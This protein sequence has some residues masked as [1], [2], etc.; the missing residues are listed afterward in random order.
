VPRNNADRVVR[1]RGASSAPELRSRVGRTAGVF[2]GRDQ[3]MLDLRAALDD[4]LAGQ[5]C[6]VTLV[7]EPGIGKTRAAQELGA[8][9]E[10]QGAL[11][12]WG[13][14]Y[15]GEGAPPYWPWIQLLRQYISAHDAESLLSQMG[16]AAAIIA[17]VVPELRDKLPD[18]EPPSALDSGA[19]TRFRLFDSISVFFKRASQTNP[20]VLV[21]EDLH[22]ADRSSLLLLEFV[23]KDI[24]SMKV[25]LLG[26]YRDVEVTRRHPLSQTLGNL[27]RAQ[28]F[29]EIQLQGLDQEQVGQL[30]Q[31][32]SGIVPKGT[33]VQTIHK[34]T[35]GNPLFVGEIVRLLSQSELSEGL[36]VQTGIPVGVRNAIG[37]RL[38]RR[39]EECNGVLTV[40]SVVG[41]EFELRL[42]TRLM[43]DL[44]E[45][46][47]IGALEEAIEAR[48]IEEIPLSPGK[49]RFTHALVQETLLEEVSITRRVRLHARIAEALEASYGAAVESH[50]AELAYHLYQAQTVLGVDKLVHYLLAAGEQALSAYAYEEAV[51]HFEKALAVEELE[52]QPRRQAE[53]LENLGVAAGLVSD[54]RAVEYFERAL[55][56]YD[57]LGDDEKAGTVHLHLS[58]QYSYYRAR[59]QDWA[60]SFD[61]A[62]EAIKLLEPRGDSVQLA[63]A[64]ARQGFTAR[65]SSGRWAGSV[66][67]L[68]KGLAMSERLGD[69]TGALY[70]RDTLGGALYAMGQVQRALTMLR[71]GV[72]MARASKDLVSLAELELTL[73]FEY[74]FL[75]DPGEMSRWADDLSNV[76]DQTGVFRHRLAASLFQAQ[77]WVLMGDG[78]RA[79]EYLGKAQELGERAEMEP[80][81]FSNPAGFAPGLVNYLLGRW[82][83]AEREWRAFLEAKAS[84]PYK[85]AALGGLCRIALDQGDFPHAQKLMDDLNPVLGVV[86]LFGGWLRRFLP[87][88]VELSCRAGNL[89][90]AADRVYRARESIEQEEILRGQ[91]GNIHLAEGLLATAQ[92]RWQEAEPAFEKATEIYRKYKVPYYE[93]RALLERG[94][95]YLA[96]NGS[97]DREHQMQMLDEALAIFQRIQ[98]EKMVEKVLSLQKRAESQPG[99]L[100]AYPDG[101]TPR[102]VEVLRLIAAGKT[103]REIA[104]ELFISV[105]TVSTHVRNLLNKTNVANRSEAVGYAARHG[106]V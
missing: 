16:P 33:L 29:Y 101:L 2:V 74:A 94:G 38:D 103:D 98:S 84:H 24:G 61:H 4:A 8:I 3:E 18:L 69:I 63:R 13:N 30:V 86:T 104:G 32:A 22:W 62:T 100:P 26:T 79:L 12:L 73:S 35:E 48:I 47:L 99:A 64:Y 58:M 28:S 39:S 11:V 9:G 78:P 19:E 55:V 57:R 72:K 70:A 88:A 27:V 76:A 1:D 15:E 44:S 53:L 93:G 21:L 20:L 87:E 102:E 14:C 60:K 91:M 68:E 43:D 10:T 51:E 46:H 7:G 17:E 105:T 37:Q 40:A 90:I 85:W 56:I 31:V 106:L 81:A 66:A 67:L 96:R 89:E 80:S 34:R 6:L 83:E 92:G 59:D 82:D 77:A 71:E 65:R 36:G 25:L 95:M 5:G 23:A 41:V 97:G 42:L 49:Y 50:A 52:G 54:K 75:L 45:P